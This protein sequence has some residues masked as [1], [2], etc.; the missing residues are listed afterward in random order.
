MVLVR[1]IHWTR[2]VS[3]PNDSR[4]SH[5]PKIQTSRMFRSSSWCS[6]RLWKMEDA[7]PLLK[8]LVLKSRYLDTSTEAQMDQIMVQYGRSSR[9][10]FSKG[11]CTVT[12][13]QD[14]CGKGKLRKFYSNTVGKSFKLGVFLRQPSKKDFVKMCMWMISNKLA[15][16]K[17][18]NRLGNYDERRWS[19]RTN[20]PR[21]RKFRMYS[22]E[23]V[24]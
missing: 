1:S 16:Q 17:T 6:V 2:I 5:G 18:W 19:G 23:T 21:P 14:Y 10:F 12:L 7:S 15:K 20:I 22:K 8:I 3:I 11:I 24:P 4:K 13:W 9:S